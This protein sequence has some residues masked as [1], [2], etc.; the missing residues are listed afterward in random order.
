MKRRLVDTG[1]VGTCVVRAS[2][3]V[4]V[5]T[6]PRV[7]PRAEHAERPKEDGAVWLMRFLAFALVLFVSVLLVFHG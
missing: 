5:K 4:Q 3:R 6:Q 7:H 1:S 2:P